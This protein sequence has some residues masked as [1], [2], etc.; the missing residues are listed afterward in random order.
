[1]AESA[2]VNRGSADA[3]AAQVAEAAAIV[4]RTFA[5]G[6]KLLICGNGGSAADSQHIATEFTSTLTR[7][8]ERRSL[9]A[10][11]LTTDSSFMTAFSNDFSF[12]GTFARLVEGLG[13][14]GDALIGL[15]TSGNSANIVRAF[16]KANETGI[17]TISFTG[18]D[19]RKMAGLARVAIRVPS[20]ITG[21][22]QE[23]HIALAHAF[24][25]AVEDI[26][27]GADARAAAQSRKV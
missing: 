11:A 19:G 2:E 27:F 16:E 23:A 17:S 12:E 25:S 8:F 6:G 3:C 24:C 15:S 5:A 7:D 1:M 10:I 4:A 21:H 18:Q 13:R 20:S 14:S 26:L 9:P 22:I